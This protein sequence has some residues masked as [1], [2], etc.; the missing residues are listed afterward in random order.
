MNRRNLIRVAIALVLA[1]AFIAIWFSP[2]RQYVT[3]ENVQ[4]FV[5]HL[6]GLWYGPLA[7]IGAFAVACVLALPASVFV[8]AAGFIWGWVLGGVYSIIGGLIGAVASFYV[9]RFVGEGLLER[10]GRAGKAVA[11]KVDHAGFRSM[12][13]LRFIPGI[14]FAVLNYGAGVAR[15][16]FVDYFFTTL[17]GVIPGMFVFAYCSDA[18]LNGSMTGQDA[19][20]RLAGVCGVMLV[21]I[22]LPMAV[23]KFSKRVPVVE[24]ANEE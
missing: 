7:F 4:R 9:G 20:L 8:I 13:I 2:L 17:I 12:L 24:L 18:L 1:A 3:R 14:P 11:R 21:F 16:R 6:R 23:K 10:F 15:V 19:F 5:E 22:L